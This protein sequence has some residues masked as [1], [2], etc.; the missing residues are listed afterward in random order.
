MHFFLFHAPCNRAWSTAIQ[1][2]T[3][4]KELDKGRETGALLR[5]RPSI[6]LPPLPY[7]S[8]SSF[9]L[10]LPFSFPLPLTLFC[11][12][13][14]PPTISH[15][16]GLV[17]PPRGQE[18]NDNEPFPPLTLLP[19][20]MHCQSIRSLSLL[21]PLHNSHNEQQ[22]ANKKQKA[23]Y[24]QVPSTLAPKRLMQSSHPAC[25]SVTSL[26]IKPPLFYVVLNRIW[27]QR[28][29]VYFE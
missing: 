1:A 20:R 23:L 18:R 7:F 13:Y 16:R 11:P 28:R 21:L 15:S 25:L 5:H 6:S 22:K 8:F 12:H 3:Q 2:D 26:K 29:F 19:C 10:F 14:S 9:V 4:T 27:R 24:D 17:C